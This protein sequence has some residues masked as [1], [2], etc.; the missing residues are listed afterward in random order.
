MYSTYD[1]TFTV[2]HN[3]RMHGEY[4]A[5]VQENKYQLDYL[6]TAREHGTSRLRKHW[7]QKEAGVIGNCRVV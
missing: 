2:T 1:D 5:H 7:L 3:I 6:N 4:I